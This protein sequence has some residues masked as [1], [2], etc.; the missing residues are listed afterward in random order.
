MIIVIFV[1]YQ[2]ISDKLTPSANSYT[3]VISIS[4]HGENKNFVVWNVLIQSYVSVTGDSI[5]EDNV[6]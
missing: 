6:N 1:Y 3:G 2:F 5:S 4:E